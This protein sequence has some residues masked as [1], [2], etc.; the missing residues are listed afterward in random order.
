MQSAGLEDEYIMQV[1]WE[2]SRIC[3]LDITSTELSTDCL[4]SFLSRIPSFTYFAAGHTDFFSDRVLKHLVELKKF[5]KL[6]AIDLSFTPS[7]SEAAAVNFLQTYG[8]QLRGLMLQGK[9]TLAE[10]FWTTVIAYL[11]NIE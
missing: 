5:D 11:P 9:P 2:N 1:P 4:D 6:I 10:Y 8:P 3:E 7:I